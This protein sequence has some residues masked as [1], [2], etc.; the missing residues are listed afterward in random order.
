MLLPRLA[1]LASNPPDI[2]VSAARGAAPSGGR[3]TTRRHAG[4]DGW[5]GGVLGSARAV[6]EMATDKIGS[7]PGGVDALPFCGRRRST[8]RSA[9]NTAI[10][11]TVV[12]HALP[13]PLPLPHAA[14]PGLCGP[15]IGVHGPPVGGTRADMAT[16]LIDLFVLIGLCLIFGF[17]FCLLLLREDL[18]SLG[19]R[20]AA[21]H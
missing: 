4:R 20:L 3:L 8:P 12:M 15:G 2:A 13:L 18:F 19:R 14:W 1:G 7:F 21:P 11:I 10:G 5:S 9:L 17:P 6:A 16:V